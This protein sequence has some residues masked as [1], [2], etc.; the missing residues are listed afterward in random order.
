MGYTGAVFK[1][2]F[3]NSLGLSISLMALIFWVAILQLFLWV[4][5]RRKDF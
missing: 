2:F 3:G 5:V 4:I 1:A